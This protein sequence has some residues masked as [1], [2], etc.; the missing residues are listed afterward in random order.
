[1]WKFLCQFVVLIFSMQTAMR[2]AV[3]VLDDFE[4]DEGHF[5]DAPSFSGS[6]GGIAAPTSTADRDT[7]EANTGGAS[8]RLFIDDDP[9]T[10]ISGDLWRVRHLSGRGNIV[11][12]VPLSGGGFVGFFAKTLTPNLQAS[13][14]IDDS[15]TALER[16]TFQPML[17][18]GLWHLYQWNLADEADWQAFAL[19]DAN[20]VID[21]PT[22]TIDSLYFVPTFDF[23]LPEQDATMFIDDVA[24]NA[25]G[26]IPDIVPEPTSLT[27]LTI[28]LLAIARRRRIQ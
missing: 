17:P 8:Q 2:A 19:A 12:N 10:F 9:N 18:D 24:Y 26:R 27:F 7:T 25:D 11:Q 20:G 1:M 5:A 16:A 3:V 23:N 21:N 15:P 14:M 13:L 22:V 28:G 6:T 4:I